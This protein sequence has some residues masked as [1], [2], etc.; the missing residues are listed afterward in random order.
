MDLGQR[1]AVTGNE[2]LGGLGAA[3]V[4]I[5]SAPD[6]HHQ[7]QQQQRESD[8][9]DGQNAAPLVAKRAFGDEAGQGHATPEDAAVDESGRE[10]Q[11]TQFT[12][13]L[14]IKQGLRY[15]QLEFATSIRE[16]R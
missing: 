13:A 12:L 15:G 6:G 9:Q 10:K 16:H 2:A 11:P 4:D 3:L 7:S 1:N 14:R 8:A 5:E